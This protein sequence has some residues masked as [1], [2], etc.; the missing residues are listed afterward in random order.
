MNTK[1][2]N[3]KLTSGE[4]HKTRIPCMI[5]KHRVLKTDPTYK[6]VI[7]AD[8]YVKSNV[9]VR[10][11]N[12]SYYYD[13]LNIL[14]PSSTSVITGDQ[15][16]DFLE[17]KYNITLEQ[18]NNYH[19]SVFP[20]LS[21][22][23]ASDRDLLD[24]LYNTLSDTMY[25]DGLNV[26]VDFT[27]QT[28]GGFIR[29]KLNIDTNRVKSW[30]VDDLSLNLLSS[31]T[32]KDSNYNFKIKNN[33]KNDLELSTEEVFLIES[34]LK[35]N[36]NLMP[37]NGLAPYVW[38]FVNQLPAL[39]LTAKQYL[40]GFSLDKVGI[41]NILNS[42]FNLSVDSNNKPLTVITKNGTYDKPS[43]T[44]NISKPN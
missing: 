9:A 18:G 39:S 12:G 26:F 42:D 36:S 1:N 21:F 6:F 5:L 8:I 17:S 43:Q 10:N 37:N 11:N 16:L 24:Q 13:L 4:W 30:I 38:D 34:L 41:T 33:Y 15:W 23:S 20:E 27:L 3:I 32:T 25:S 7:N 19:S 14:A 29:N 31:I 22:E 2:T 44:I 28:S 40:F 35:F